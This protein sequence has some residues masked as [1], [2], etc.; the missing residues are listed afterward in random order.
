MI[1][2]SRRARCARVG[3]KEDI[4]PRYITGA[5]II[6][7]IAVTAADIV[8]VLPNAVTR[9]DPLLRDIAARDDETCGLRGRE[10]N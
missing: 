6:D 5:R 8:T 4:R 7:T 2:Y 10:R 3:C 1:V 9:D